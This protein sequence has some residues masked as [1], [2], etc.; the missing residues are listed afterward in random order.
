MHAGIATRS[1]GCGL[2]MVAEDRLR[3]E[4]S[5]GIKKVRYCATLHAEHVFHFTA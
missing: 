3:A 2:F 4:A 1:E 5:A